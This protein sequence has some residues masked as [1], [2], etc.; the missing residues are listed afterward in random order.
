MAGSTNGPFLRLSDTSG[1]LFEKKYGE[2]V[3]KRLPVE[4]GLWA[5]Y[6]DNVPCGT[7]LRSHPY[8]GSADLTRYR[9]MQLIYCDRRV[10]CPTTNIASYRV[11]G[12]GGWVAEKGEDGTP[13]LLPEHKVKVGTFAFEVAKGSDDIKLCKEPS[14]GES[15]ELPVSFKEGE[16]VICDVIRQSP[17]NHSQNGPFLR[18]YDG[19]GWLYEKLS[20]TN[21]RMKQVQIEKGHWKFEVMNNPAGIAIRR[22]PID[23][24]GIRTDKTFSPGEIINCDRKIKSSGISTFYRVAGQDGWVFDRRESCEMMR[25]VSSQRLA[26]GEDLQ[27]S[28][29]GWSVE[30]IRGVAMAF[31]LKEIIHNETSRVISFKTDANERINIYYTTRTVGTALNHPSQ[32]ATQL[33]RRNCS[34]EELR[35][36]M[37]NPRVHTG[38]GYKKRSRVDG[39]NGIAYGHHNYEDQYIDEEED[40]RNRLIEYEQEEERIASKKLKVLKAIKSID[41]KRANS[42]SKMQAKIDARSEE[43]KRIQREKE[44]A[45]RQRQREREEAERKQR[46]TCSVCGV[47]FAN[48]HAKNQHFQAVQTFRCD[49]CYKNFNSRNALNQHKNAVN[50]WGY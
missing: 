7:M 35:E 39:Q 1:W 9:P 15:S 41:D 4:K 29:I 34:D 30:F 13:I 3:A 38:K 12:T 24:S 16:I 40:Y 46:C 49:Y 48:E 36:I 11:Q 14:V 17:S 31:Q 23:K 18:L 42:A 37:Q 10:V 22:H 27:Q 44:E 20:G 28:E 45:E 2:V 47:L 5:F 19:W 50:H 33:F 21:I 25:L 43:F 32:G 26:P 8:I 6:V